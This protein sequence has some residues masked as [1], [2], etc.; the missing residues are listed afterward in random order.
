MNS[1]IR[2]LISNEY[3]NFA[4]SK[5]YRR[6]K[7]IK[8]MRILKLGTA[9]AMW[10]LFPHHYKLHDDPIL[11]K[12]FCLAVQTISA[13]SIVETGTFM[14][15]STSFMA[16]KFPNI[17]IHTCEINRRHYLIAKKNLRKYPNVNVH[18]GESPKIMEKLIK[19]KALG[20]R[21]LFF[22]DA[23]WLDNW[24]LEDEMRLI[25][26]LLKKAVVMI[27]DFKIPERPEFIYDKYGKKECSIE[28]IAPHMLKKNS[29]KLLLPNYG[30]EIFKN[31]N[32]HPVL[33]GYPIIFQNFDKEY[34]KFS[35]DGFMKKFFKD[36]TS[37]LISRIKK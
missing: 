2:N 33:S 29:Y 4:S 21:P 12:S 11:Q 18:F 5:S 17:P 22:L 30:R 3:D 28:L 7:N 24:P 15:Y 13:T 6:L 26:H 10:K 36:K 14:G 25:T 9:R 35:N 19:D 16:E 1:R 20:E 37:L 23:H 32:Y 27:D 31:S 8:I 34:I